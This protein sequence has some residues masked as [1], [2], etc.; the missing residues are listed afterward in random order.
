[1]WLDHFEKDPARRYKLSISVDEQLTLYGSADGLQWT[2]IGT[3]GRAFDRSTFF[4]NAF[5]RKWVFSVRGS[6]RND[7]V[8]Y[9]HEGADFLGAASWHE[10]D[11]VLWTAA[12]RLDPVRPGWASRA[13]LYN[14]DAVSY[15][16]MLLGLF[17]IW[18]GEPAEREKINEI[19]L[20]YSRDGF[21]W[22]RPDRQAFIG[23]SDH[24]G[25]WNWANVQS[26]GG[27]CVVVGDHLYFYVSGRSGVP[28]TNGPGR[29]S[30]GLAVIRRDGFASMER[31]PGD[32]RVRPAS[33][34]PDATLT[35]RPIRFSGS[36]LFVNADLTRGDLR[37]EVLDVDGRVI[38]PF[39]RDNCEPLH[40]DG[41]RMAVR[42]RSGESLR[43]LAGRTVR[44][45]FYL[46][47]GRLYAFW[48]SRSTK[49][50]S[51]GYVA[52]GGPGFPGPI[53]TGGD[54]T[55]SAD[56]TQGQAT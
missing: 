15:E 22:S 54:G 31:L 55:A 28:G 32:T 40:G 52:A 33:L 13:E 34:G 12:D 20:G 35:T 23:V 39:T 51:G 44:L 14:L 9:Y 43:A 50:A 41:T 10:S 42:W 8:R 36:H 16:S 19:C 37:A 5:R 48:V 45:R 7:R 2:K 21:H 4:Y 3:S 49:G 26:A 53:D 47:F 24:V 30:T 18:R 56:G 29:S 25:D 1:V 11:L 38:A 6:Y 17:S 46:T 27:G